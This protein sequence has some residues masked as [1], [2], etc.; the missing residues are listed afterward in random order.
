MLSALAVASD[1][2][3]FRAPELLRGVA[4]AH[5]AAILPAHVGVAPARDLLL[6][7]R[8]IDAHEAQRSGLIARVVPHDRLV[9][10]AEHAPPHPRSLPPEA[11]AQCKPLTNQRYGPTHYVPF[12]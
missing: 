3:T 8:R 1:R 2:A 12:Q 10:E 9:E 7:A 6:T 5:L 4:D 11:R